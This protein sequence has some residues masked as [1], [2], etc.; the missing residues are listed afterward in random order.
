[1]L[2]QRSKRRYLPGRWQWVVVE[3]LSVLLG[4]LC[5]AWADEVRLP[6]RSSAGYVSVMEFLGGNV[7]YFLAGWISYS[8]VFL[9]MQNCSHT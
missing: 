4:L 1:M 8:V 2:P 7:A 9:G 6:L 5:S 3:I